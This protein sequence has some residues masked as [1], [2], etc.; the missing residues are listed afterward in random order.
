MR[1][2]RATAALV[3]AAMAPAPALLAS[4]PASSASTPGSNTKVSVPQGTGPAALRDAGVFGTTPA[5]TPETVAF[6]LKARNLGQLEAAVE[7]GRTGRLSVAQF[8]RGYGQPGPVISALES[9][10]R[11]FGISSAA[12]PD[13]L[14]VTATGKAGQFNRAL[15]VQQKDYSV[16]AVKGRDGRPGVPAQ[17]V[18][19]TTQSP[20]LPYRIAQ[21]VLSIL[22]LTNY[23][24]FVS[25]A[26]HTP[27]NVSR[28][29]GP[30]SPTQSRT[31][32][33]GNLTPRDFAASYGVDPLY[34]Q[35]ATGKGTTI[36]IVTL[37]GLN[38]ATPYYFWRHVLGLSAP[39]GRIT[40]DNVDGGPGGPSEAAGSGETDLDVEQAGAV[41]PGAN[42]VVYQAPNTDTGFA[43]AFFSA[44]SQNVADTVS[45][46]WGESETYIAAGVAA[47]TE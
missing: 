2:R 34:R 33:T 5:S 27:A 4:G 47:G 6:V 35:G 32:Y 9:Y 25:N 45:S 17:R 24:S 21:D 3:V 23:S 41:A 20:M 29:P 16:P 40:V 42:L 10:L 8:A 1:L 37:A 15:S 36:G 28:A 12:Y 18:H 26:A 22:G 39:A 43:D 7:S 30:V 46:S 44:A 31:T 11:P 19:G 38:P 14:D 13:G